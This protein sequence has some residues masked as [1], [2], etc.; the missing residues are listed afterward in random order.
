MESDL[1]FVRW[2]ERIVPVLLYSQSV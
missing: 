2:K 1:C